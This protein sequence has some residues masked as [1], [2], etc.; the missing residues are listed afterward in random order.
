M[1]AFVA[2]YAFFLIVVKDFVAR[3]LPCLLVTVFAIADVWLIIRYRF[4]ESWQ[5]LASLATVVGVEVAVIGVCMAW[6]QIQIHNSVRRTRIITEIYDAFL[7][8]DLC[9]FYD[10]VRNGD[11]IRWDDKQTKDE[12][13]LNQSLTRF[14]EICYLQTQKLF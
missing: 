8:D 5:E 11:R 6:T 12:M 2:K 13:L 7:T 4:P 14:D 3:N 10:R 1:K 9:K